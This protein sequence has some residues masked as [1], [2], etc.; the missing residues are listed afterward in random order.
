MW[1]IHS[2][3]LLHAAV[4]LTCRLAGI[5]DELLLT[6]LTMT[7]VLLVCFRKNF[8]IEFTAA[9]IIISNILGYLFGTVG[10]SI[11][12]QF[13]STP[14]AVHAISTAITTEIL[15]W[16]VVG[17]S[18]LF[19]KMMSESASK[20]S[21]SSI[22]WA[23][24][25]AGGIFALRL[26]IVFIFSQQSLGA[27]K[28]FEVT[29]RVLSNS[30][31]IIVLACLNI[32]F[33]RNL[34][35]RN[36]H[37]SKFASI[38]SGCAF[39]LAC[40]LLETVLAG[41]GFP[42]RIHIDFLKDFAFLFPVSL[43]AQIT[44]YSLVYIV[45]YAVAAKTQ[46]RQEREKANMAQYR[47]MKL[48]G[49]VNPHFL[50]NSLNILD[51]LVCEEKTDEASTYIHKLAGIY[52]YMIKSEDEDIVP[53]R[54][55]MTFVN[56]YVDLLRLRFPEGFEVDINVPEQEMSRY[57]LPCALQLLIENATKHNAVTAANPLKISVEVVGDRL[58]VC[59]NMV[60]K[61]TR[62]ESTGL[63]QKYIRQQYMDLSGKTIE[64]ENDGKNYSVTLPLL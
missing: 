32:L 47:Y 21:T 35:N 55:E 50:F 49:Q 41:S 7:M 8:S 39:M 31:G 62:V 60:P 38:T 29:S 24:I 26:L 53:L 10:A 52:R 2:F 33:I 64:I 20:L 59:N 15:G 37:C 19:P 34:R 42:F 51:C 40:A 22:K 56:Q 44:V 48:K 58:R 4:A 54:D 28:V 27:E 57:V 17:I 45:N 6:L 25:A 30:V 43:L 5:E 14:L 9:V 11:L 3:A 61:V 16:C 13:I 46:M 1:V 36:R 12:E 18:K 23:L 63:G